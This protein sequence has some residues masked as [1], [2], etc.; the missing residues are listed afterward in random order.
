M[1]RAQRPPGQDSPKAGHFAPADQVT[2]AFRFTHADLVE[3]AS[4]CP[5]LI[6]TIKDGERTLYHL[7]DVRDI[8]ASTTPVRPYRGDLA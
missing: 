2:A 5:A 6:D 8:A 4:G 1:I 7:E 3:M